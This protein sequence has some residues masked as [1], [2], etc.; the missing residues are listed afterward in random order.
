MGSRI[1]DFESR[2]NIRKP[3]TAAGV[4]GPFPR[5]GEATIRVVVEDAA[6]GNTIQPQG[7]LFGQTAWQNIGSAIAGNASGTEVDVS[8]Y[9]EWRLNV[10]AYA[11][12]GTE[13]KVIASGFFFEPSSGG[14]GATPTGNSNSYALFDNSGDLFSDVGF[15]FTN[16]STDYTGLRLNPTIADTV[17]GVIG[18]TF[19]PTIDGATIG[20]HRSIEI[21]GNFGATDPTP[22]NNIIEIQVGPQHEPNSDVDNYTGLNMGGTWDAGSLLD[23]YT[24]INIPTQ[25]D[26]S[27]T[28]ANANGFVNNMNF[29][30]NGANVTL[31]NYKGISENPAWH[32]ASVLND[33]M[34]LNIGPTFDD[35]TTVATYTGL[36][37]GQGGTGTITNAAGLRIT[38]NGAM[39]TGSNVSLETQGGIVQIGSQATLLSAQTFQTGNNFGA[40]FTNTL[41]ITGTDFIG[42]SLV[43]TLNALDDIAVGPVGIGFNQV[44][45]VGQITVAAGKTVDQYNGVLSGYSWGAGTGAIT[46]SNAYVAAGAISAGGTVTNNRAFYVSPLFNS[47]P[48]VNAWGFHNQ[49]DTDNYFEKNVLVGD[50]APTSVS[51]GIE[52][53]STTK[54][55][56][57]A[58]MDTT[59]RNALTAVNGMQIY[60]TTTDKLQAYAAGAWVDLH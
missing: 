2:Y 20:G 46:D 5:R 13:V 18:V 15:T 43:A 6:G 37:I 32:N 59:Q 60:N 39:I 1:K 22:I 54:A 57:N 4:I 44:G 8:A 10:T 50:D 31:T 42:N 58:R 9:D 7:R 48:A 16:N 55:F 26:S 17:L 34:G 51:V 19:N 11:T 35:T 21:N 53:D 45:F 52:I 25:I 12:S 41:P 38:M 49:T 56:L 24:A 14:G 3:V 29:G 47:T 27:G 33:Y 28:V 40:N 36:S 23:N 30:L